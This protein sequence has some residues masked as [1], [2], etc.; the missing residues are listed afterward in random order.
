M[1]TNINANL[2]IQEINP[3]INFN[4]RPA[5]IGNMTTNE[6]LISDK[7]ELSTEVN[8]L[9]DEAAKTDDEHKKINSNSSKSDEI[10]DTVA[11]E[12]RRKMTALK[13]AQRIAKGDN[14]P[15]QDHRFLAEYDS[16]LYKAS[17]KA[18]LTVKNDDPETHE[19]LADELLEIENAINNADNN[20]SLVDSEDDSIDEKTDEL[21]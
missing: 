5:V 13:I 12:A 7:L 19:S 3:K 1:V 14:V 2:K 15:M 21:E 8:T 9:L 18:S 6:E 20:E 10:D 11:T 17:L 4:K 16:A